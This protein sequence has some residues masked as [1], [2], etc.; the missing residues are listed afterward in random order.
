MC[1]S[2]TRRL[3]A[4]LLTLASFTTD[5]NSLYF[6]FLLHL[7]TFVYRKSFSTSS[8]HQYL[9]TPTRTLRVIFNK[10]LTSPFF[11]IHSHRMSQPLHYSPC[12]IAWQISFSIY[13]PQFLQIWFSKHMLSYSSV[14]LPQNFPLLCISHNLSF[15]EINRA[16]HPYITVDF[17]IATYPGFA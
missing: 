9:G 8:N 6:A 16:S 12:N 5:T 3:H 10:I 15:S 17:T 2:L 13:L 4:P 1:T 7:F 14:H 11:C